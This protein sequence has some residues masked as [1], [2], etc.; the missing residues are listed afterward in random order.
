MPAWPAYLL[1]FASI[2]L[3][4]PTLVRRL[5]DRIDPPAARGVRPRW[6]VL[7]VVVT[8]AVPAVATVA[9]TRIKPPTPAVVQ[10]FEG[11]NILTPVDESIHVQVE[12]TSSGQ[13]VSWTTGSWRGKVFYKVYRGPGGGHDVQCALSFATAWSCYLRMTIVN[14]TSA[15]SYVDPSPPA[16][17]VYRVGVGSNWLDD[18]DLGDVYAISPA[19]QAQ[20]R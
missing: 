2:P 12:R 19:V 6:V 18:P 7:A 20:D 9:S 14:T 13:R 10:E 17:S 11:G 4:V 3:L 16:G 15:T 1:L 5:G 8:V